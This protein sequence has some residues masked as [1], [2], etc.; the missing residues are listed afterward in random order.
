[1]VFNYPPSYVDYRNLQHQNGSYS[2]L[3]L[4]GLLQLS[5]FR[6][7]FLVFLFLAWLV[8]PLTPALSHTGEREFWPYNDV[9]NFA[10]SLDSRLRGNDNITVIARNAVTWQS[11]RCIL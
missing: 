2:L 11:P 5:L 1:M 6:M 7:G 10:V 4:Q 3:L 9:T 8:G